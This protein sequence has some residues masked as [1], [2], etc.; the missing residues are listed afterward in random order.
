MYNLTCEANSNSLMLK[1]FKKLKHS[2]VKY[3]KISNL[4]DF[5][6]LFLVYAEVRNSSISVFVFSPSF[7]WSFLNSFQVDFPHLNLY[8]TS[9][10]LIYRSS[11]S[12]HQYD[13]SLSLRYLLDLIR[14]VSMTCLLISLYLN[15][16]LNCLNPKLFGSSDKS[17]TLLQAKSTIIFFYDL[18]TCSKINLSIG[19]RNP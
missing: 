6:F 13:K 1:T 7:K 3:L 12:L 15:C 9:V 10:L 19:E 8:S 5:K 18:Q 11:L 4:T 2:F 17:T 14:T 16:L